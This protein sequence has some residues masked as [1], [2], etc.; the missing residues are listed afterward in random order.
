MI[1]TINLIDFFLY[2]S[3]LNSF[4]NENKKKI[5]L[6]CLCSYE[7]DCSQNERMHLSIQYA[8]QLERENRG[9]GINRGAD[10]QC[11]NV[12]KARTKLKRWTCSIRREKHHSLT[13][14][15]PTALATKKSHL[16]KDQHANLTPKNDE[17]FCDCFHKKKCK[18]TRMVD[19]YD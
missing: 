17:L 15:A 16:S 4:K 12:L 2:S 3:F 10:Y 11:E 13:T 1:S 9:K 18:H 7:T 14:S 6:F 8:A 5:P 19:F